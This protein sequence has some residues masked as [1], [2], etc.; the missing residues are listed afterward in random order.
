[1]KKLHVNWGVVLLL[2]LVFCKP[3][4]K[5][6]AE[7]RGFENKPVEVVKLKE[8]FDD[9]LGA[10]S[11]A[12][13]EKED[14]F[15]KNSL[16]PFLSRYCQD[17]HNADKRKGKFDITYLTQKADVKKYISF[18]Q[19]VADQI[20]AGDMPPE[21]EPQASAQETSN[22]IASIRA[23]IERTNPY[24]NQ[25]VLRR[26]NKDEYFNTLNDLFYMNDDN[27]FRDTVG[28]PPDQ[29]KHGVTNN[30]E[31]L[32]TSGVLV[33][34]Y[35]KAAREVIDQVLP[36]V[37]VKKKYSR[38][39]LKPPFLANVRDFSTSIYGK[40]NYQDIVTNEIG[41]RISHLYAQKF[42][43]G[44]KYDGYYTVKLLIEAKNRT[45]GNKIVLG[46][47]MSKGF[48]KNQLTV[49][50][51][52]GNSKL[53]ILARKS[54][55]DRFL[56]EY[57]LP[58]DKPHQLEL[59]VWLKKSESLKFGFPMGLDTVKKSKHNFQKYLQKNKNSPLNVPNLSE[60][61]K[62]ASSWSKF[63][64]Q[65]SQLYPTLRFYRIEVAG[66]LFNS[67][68]IVNPILKGQ[69]YTDL[70]LEKTIA[71]FSE[72][73]FRRPLEPAE[74]QPIQ[75][76]VKSTYE[77]TGSKREAL[78]NGLVAILSS[79]QFYYH[80]ENPEQLDDYALASRLSYFLWSTMPDE[81]LLELAKSK[82]LSSNTAVLLKEVERMLNDPRSD[83]LV[84]KLADQW[85]G[86]HKLDFILPDDEKEYRR[87]NLKHHSKYETYEFLKYILNS[88]RKFMDIIN[89][90]YTFLNSNLAYYY[91]LENYDKFP[92]NN[93][94]R[95]KSIKNRPKGVFGHMGLLT[96]TANGVDTSPIIRG[97]WM[98]ET[99]LGKTLPPPPDAVPAIEP[100]IRNAKTIRDQLEKHRENAACF[101]CHQKFDHFGF[102]LEGFDELG[103]LRT[104]YTNGVK[105][106]PK[107]K[108]IKVEIDTS[109]E[110]AHGE[111][112]NDIHSLID[113]LSQKENRFRDVVVKNLLTLAVGREINSNESEAIAEISSNLKAAGDGLAD[114]VK[115]VALSKAFMT[116]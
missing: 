59:K 64:S 27:A 105:N 79:P 23:E 52:A 21:D 5:L 13:T 55:W 34:T 11:I 12:T 48:I 80:F 50:V 7:V 54:S 14:H 111:K 16:K 2:L 60:G 114:A 10:Q 69:S 22:F 26:L 17:C 51:Y 49:R 62:A 96:A 4:M 113:I 61:R 101:S 92:T 93:Y 30:G 46:G 28:F 99:F 89:A 39:V 84:H 29:R 116:K 100:D 67:T 1:M 74:I 94:V 58:D 73:A 71:D 81:R 53:G 108:L 42:A 37:E 45:A 104:H 110:T 72:R 107:T 95:V 66:P 86:L 41:P 82:G 78:V 91:G 70:D 33:D 35:I 25:S 63:T 20:S 36:V 97:V 32:I 44:V 98:Y 3:Q 90:D 38:V 83:K 102:A 77:K 31:A 103:R 57:S 68:K 88:N 9:S 15:Y 65:Y 8:N 75:S 106:V 24:Y 115:Q 47:Q 56:G 76:Y 109:G 112:F 87:L 18:L 6:V 43:N 40:K 19:E 85:L